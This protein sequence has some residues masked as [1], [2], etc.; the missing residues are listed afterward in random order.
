MNRFEGVSLIPALAGWMQHHFLVRELINLELRIYDPS[1]EEERFARPL[2]SQ[3]PSV[4]RV[5]A[6]TRPS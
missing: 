1:A 3:S 5:A 2:P 4:G 6:I